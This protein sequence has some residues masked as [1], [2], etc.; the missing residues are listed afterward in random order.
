MAELPVVPPP[1]LFDVTGALA[2]RISPGDSVKLALLR[3][4]DSMH[5]VSVFLEIWD[6]GGSQPLNTHPG[7]VE[8]FLVL[9]GTGT[10]YCDETVVALWPGQLL[11]LPPR[12]MHRIENSD[13][14]RLYAVTTMAPDAGFA[15]LVRAGTPEPLEP[16]DLE[17]VGWA[18][19]R[20]AR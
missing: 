10:A 12:S 3:P 15:G 9:A 8:T 19:S 6:P 20:P 11:V 18:G 2:Y 16:E 7:S 4:P 17:A 1:Q 13:A 14:G 5:D